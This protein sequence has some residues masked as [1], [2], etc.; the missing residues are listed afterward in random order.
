[1]NAISFP[2]FH[3]DARWQLLSPAPSPM[4][5]LPSPSVAATARSSSSAFSNSRE[6]GYNAAVYSGHMLE[7]PTFSTI[8]S[9]PSARLP[10]RSQTM[11]QH[12]QACSSGVQQH[13]L[14]DDMAHIDNMQAFHEQFRPGS[15]AALS[16]AESAS[17][18][19]QLEASDR[20]SPVSLIAFFDSWCLI[21]PAAANCHCCAAAT[22][23]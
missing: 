12:L 17:L 16:S 8:R 18:K 22:A 3:C 9:S 20:A 15:P 6:Q 10:P 13:A 14:D 23:N 7:T 21:A 5:P 2:C 11:M 1:M 4:K 19:L